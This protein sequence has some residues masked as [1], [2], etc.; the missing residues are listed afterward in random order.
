M[1][2]EFRDHFGGM[3]SGMSAV[4]SAY[5]L[6]LATKFIKLS[7]SVELAAY[8]S[9]F[10]LV[11]LVLFRVISFYDQENKLKDNNKVGILFS[12]ALTSSFLAYNVI[13]FS[14]MIWLPVVSTVTFCAILAFFRTSF[15]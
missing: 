1:K 4:L 15:K 12:V 7:P 10:S 13:L 5:L 11:A 14:I 3:T 2:K 6:G 9:C 8:L